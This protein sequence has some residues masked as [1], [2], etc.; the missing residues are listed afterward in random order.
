MMN[1]KKY[2]KFFE[3]G[4]NIDNYMFFSNLE[5]MNRMITEILE[6]DKSELDQII[7]S[8]HDWAPDHISKS[9]ESL[10]HVYNW[11]KSDSRE[12]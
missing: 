2:K 12:K 8:G 3:S 6:M 4:G 11:L 7:N 5:N 1:I 9:K 10:S